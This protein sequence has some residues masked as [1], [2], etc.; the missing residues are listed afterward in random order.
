LLAGALNRISQDVDMVTFRFSYK[1]GGYGAPV[2]AR[3]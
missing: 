1:F 3:Y 2:V